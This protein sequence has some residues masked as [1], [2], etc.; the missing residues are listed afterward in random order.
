M[1]ADGRS[2]FLAL[3]GLHDLAVTLAAP[4]A[5][6]LVAEVHGHCFGEPPPSSLFAAGMTAQGVAAATVSPLL[7]ARLDRVSHKTGLLCCAAADAAV[8]FALFCL[9]LLSTAGSGGSLAYLPVLGVQ[10]LAGCTSGC[11]RAALEIYKYDVAQGSVDYAARLTSNRMTVEATSSVAVAVV[12]SAGGMQSVVAVGL[13]VLLEVTFFCVAKACV[14]DLGSGVVSVQSPVRNDSSR[15]EAATAW[16]AFVAVW[17]IPLE[18]VH[19]VGALVCIGAAPNLQRKMQFGPQT[20]GTPANLAT[21][22][23]LGKIT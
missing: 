3:T 8:Y 18:R 22:T 9:G 10:A 23:S 21:M 5:L 13:A 1:V 4:A 17:R 15:D 11:K 19:F 6:V 20:Q 2:V 12:L 14:D 16:G 7:C